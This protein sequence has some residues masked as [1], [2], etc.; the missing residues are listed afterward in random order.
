MSYKVSASSPSGELMTLGQI[1]AEVGDYNASFCDATH[2][3]VARR[4]V[5]RL[6]KV[7]AELTARGDIS[8]EDD[9]YVIPSDKS[10]DKDLT[11]MTV[12]E[13]H[14]LY[15]QWP[16]RHKARLEAGREPKTFFFEG[17]IVRELQKRKPASKEERLKIDYCTLTY[18]NELESLSIL[19]NKPIDN[20]TDKVITDPTKAYTTSELLALIRRYTDFQDIIERELLMEYIDIALDFLQTTEGRH[21]VQSLANEIEELGRKDIISIPRGV[22]YSYTNQI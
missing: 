2:L 20:G 19:F 7:T 15:R 6:N 17:R 5:N 3:S 16:S 22:G 18:Q 13:L 11:Q 12:D 8:S 1:F 4:C 9:L 10:A 21:S 14:R